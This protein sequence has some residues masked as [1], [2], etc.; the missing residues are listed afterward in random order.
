MGPLYQEDLE[1]IFR[2][3]CGYPPDDRALVLLQRLPGLGTQDQ[4]DG[5]RYFIDEHF[6]QIAKAGE[7]VRFIQDPYNYQIFGDPRQWKETLQEIG[8]EILC[9]KIKNI[10][11]GIVEEAVL[12]AKNSETEVLATD[13]LLALNQLGIS[14][15]RERVTFTDILIPSFEIRIEEDWSKVKFQSVIFK[16]LIIE[17]TPNPNTTPIF[18]DCI[19]GKIVGYSSATLLPKDIFI[20]NEI[21]GFEIQE[22]TTSALLNLVLPVPVKVGLTILKK[23]YLQSG[24]GRQENSFYRGLSTSEQEYIQPILDFLKQEGIITPSKKSNSDNIWQP[25]KKHFGHIR[26]LIINRAYKD[27][28]IENM[29]KI[30]V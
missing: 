1:N 19:I 6:A 22:T 11:S 3:K 28:L 4:Q 10:S 27:K 30:K 20:G 2:D 7:V 14:W 29:G 13:I 25:V 15:N 23:L 9:L 26:N 12:N 17:E 18:E 16:E 21:D 5:S 8:L 24:G